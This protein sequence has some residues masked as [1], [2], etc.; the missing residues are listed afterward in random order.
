MHA[1][2]FLAGKAAPHGGV[3]AHP[4]KHGVILVQQLREGNVPADLGVE[5]ELDAHAFHQ[6]PAGVDHRF[7][8]LEGRD[9]EGQQTADL[10]ITVVHHRCNAVARQNVCTAEA[11]GTGA[12]N[13]Y[14]LAGGD[15]L[16]QVGAPALLDGLIGDVFLDRADG[17]RAEA[18]VHGAGALAQAVL[19]AD[20]AA[21]LR[22]ELV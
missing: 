19:R 9:A 17:H 16:R 3:G 1:F 14:A 12:D 13:G 15:D 20:A 18:G 21:D 5:H 4:Q 8:E 11:C 10:G 2:Q 7:L 22:Q 6:L